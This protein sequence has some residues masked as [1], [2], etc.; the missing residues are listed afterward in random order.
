MSIAPAR[1]SFSIYRS[2]S[3]E[4]EESW[5]PLSGQSSGLTGGLRVCGA[6]TPTLHLFR[7]KEGGG[8]DV[9]LR[10]AICFYSS[11][12][13]TYNASRPEGQGAGSFNLSR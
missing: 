10:V 5:P 9:V 11:R 6:V 13:Y 7:E 3:F 12:V 8:G 1:T 4:P 2:L